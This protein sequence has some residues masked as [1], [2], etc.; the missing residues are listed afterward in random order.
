MNAPEPI[1]AHGEPPS[2]GI[3]MTQ[4]GESRFV[5]VA[6]GVWLLPMSTLRANSAGAKSGSV[7]V[8]SGAAH[9]GCGEPFDFPITVRVV[10]RYGEPLVDV[11]VT[12][13]LP[14][15]CAFGWE[16]LAGDIAFSFT[17]ESGTATSPVPI[18]GMREGAFSVVIVA[19]SM[20]AELSHIVMLDRL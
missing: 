14:A 5:V 4:S 17:D 1:R 18:A 3:L 10:D 2:D 6:G 16:G 9:A 12:F 7:Q 19:E 13:S 15:G 20:R 8:L 11:A